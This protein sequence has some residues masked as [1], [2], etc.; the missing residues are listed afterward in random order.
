MRKLKIF[1]LSL[2]L[3]TVAAGI[4][5]L[6]W[7]DGRKNAPAIVNDGAVSAPT[8]LRPVSAN[9]NTPI[10]T[11]KQAGEIIERFN[12]R[13]I[14]QDDGQLGVERPAHR[15]RFT[16]AGCEYTPKNAG[17]A[18]ETD[19]WRLN[20]KR[21]HR[22]DRD[23][24]RA[25]ATEAVLPTAQENIVSLDRGD[26]RER[27]VAKDVGVEL[28]FDL[29]RPPEG[30]GDLVV[31]AQVRTALEWQGASPLGL[32]FGREDKT[33]VRCGHTT[34]VD[35]LGRKL[36]VPSKYEAT[37]ETV[38]LAVSGDWLNHA[39]YPVTID[40][41]IGAPFQITPDSD[42]STGGPPLGIGAIDVAVDTA[43]GRVLVV[44]NETTPGRQ[45]KGALLDD[46][47]S[48]IDMGVPIS[49]SHIGGF[50]N[51][52]AA[53]GNT[54]MFLVVWEDYRDPTA[55][56]YGRRIDI[57]SGTI[58]VLEPSDVKISASAKPQTAPEAA[59][60]TNGVD[61]YWALVW[62]EEHFSP[63]EKIV[64]TALLDGAE[65]IFDTLS[66]AQGPIQISG[67]PMSAGDSYSSPAVA[68]DATGEMWF[69]AFKFTSVTSYTLY[70]KTFDFILD[71]PHSQGTLVGAGTTGKITV[72]Y[73]SDEG[74]PVVGLGLDTS[75]NLYEIFLNGFKDQWEFSTPKSVSLGGNTLANPCLSFNGNFF[76]L[77]FQNNTTNEVF[78]STF[79]FTE[80][81]LN[82]PSAPTLITSSTM[83]ESKPRVV[84]KG[85]ALDDWHIVW[86]GNDGTSFHAM[87]RTLDS[88]E[89][90][91]TERNVS[92]QMPHSHHPAVAFGGGC[93]LVAWNQNGGG[94]QALRVN[95]SGTILDASPLMLGPGG[96][97]PHAS[98]NGTNFVVVWNFYDMG[99]DQIKLAG[100]N[101][102]NGN[103]IE[104]GGKNVIS[105]SSYARLSGLVSDGAGKTLILYDL[106]NMGNQF[107]V[108]GALVDGTTNAVIGSPFVVAGGPDNQDTG[109]AAF[110][111][112]QNLF[113]IAYN[114]DSGTD[115]DV[116]FRRLKSD[117]TFL[118][119]TAQ[120][121]ALGANDDWLT[122]V[123][124]DGVNFT[125]FTADQSGVN[126]TI[127][128]RRFDPAGNAL[129]PAGVAMLTIPKPEYRPTLTF[130]GSVYVLAWEDEIV[131]GIKAARIFPDGTLLDVDNNGNPTP[132]TLASAGGEHP[133]LATGSTALMGAFIDETVPPAE[134]FGVSI[135]KTVLPTAALSV[136][137]NPTTVGTA[138]AF[139]GSA[140]SANAGE[141]T[142]YAF[143]FDDGSP[144]QK[145]TSATASYAY[146]AAGKY[147]ARLTVRN[148]DKGMSH[149]V[150][151]VNI[152]AV[153]D[154]PVIMDSTL[155]AAVLGVPYAH[156]L[157]VVGGVAPYNITVASGALPAGLGI[158]QAFRRIAG[159]TA[160]A[161]GTYSFALKVTDANGKSSTTQTLSI[162]VLTDL[163]NLDPTNPNTGLLLEKARI[164]QRSTSA[165]VLSRKTGRSVP[166]NAVLPETG[167]D[168]IDLRGQLTAAGL[169]FNYAD[170]KDVPVQI[171][172]G[173]LTMVLPLD[174]FAGFRTN[175][176]G[177]DLWVR[178]AVSPQTGKFRLLVRNAAL[179]AYCNN[180]E[181]VDTT[182]RLV[183]VGVSLTTVLG[184]SNGAVAAL[185]EA[186]AVSNQT[187][188]DF[189][190]NNDDLPSG[191]FVLSKFQA[192]EKDGTHAVKIDGRF[193]VGKPLQPLSSGTVKFSI[194]HRVFN[195]PTSAFDVQVDKGIL[196]LKSGAAEGLRRMEFSMQA[197]RFI[198]ETTA[199]KA[200]SDA[201]GN[202]AEA[203]IAAGTISGMYTANQTYNGKPVLAYVLY[204]DLEMPLSDN[205]TL[206]ARVPVRISRK[207]AG[208]LKWGF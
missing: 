199:M 21:I 200:H 14:E 147:K 42:D 115:V 72:D 174:E 194:G 74:S 104:P 98:F 38:L 192:L 37:T 66:V 46:D 63:S 149:A 181:V 137:P 202:D 135:S 152:F 190:F 48:V 2:V 75:I 7:K 129:E 15:L 131:G 154:T 189:R 92:L 95:E 140:S 112:N 62:E 106:Y 120:S 139:D 101:P 159:S 183:P 113:F 13:V 144:V 96:Y 49:E 3:L 146:T 207:S 99:G 5:V 186:K 78:Y 31:E 130:D 197:Q 44:Y 56:I 22:G 73:D 41:I 151:E 102:A 82:D 133:A 89:I 55:Q 187:T 145:G 23:L 26:I 124:F 201:A 107:D 33:I 178:F 122:D 128:A 150:V 54:G 80:G 61:Y 64:K 185:F 177:T 111:A 180:F 28:C 132:F 100:V 168:S 206:K 138:I 179:G 160:A 11:K 79:G 110:A 204:F 27:W 6:R 196:K 34:V 169:S 184:V 71:E 36:S 77:T 175:S 182:R 118:D 163:A 125:V 12:N 166:R 103:I 205:T 155:P 30:F 173:G 153:T 18:V 170:Y 156:D 85:V 191:A 116:Y 193:N 121:V 88:D 158:D 35:A 52:R 117:G 119:A 123:G 164:V 10:M 39:T 57:S 4:S 1:H 25:K 32:N 16:S 59:Y 53:S 68:F 65:K 24:W 97:I 17:E 67:T 157:S 134:V 141:I 58:Q 8:Q 176:S 69:V 127:R 84:S 50:G 47:G 208:D 136:S 45:V 148:T 19:A 105:P 94:I 9:E 143:D 167:E 91:G 171:V 126:I 40:P 93:Y 70:A 165:K 108:Y 142:S 203:D 198:L 83:T 87:T 51:P 114:D 195:I 60:G 29:P 188:Y 43:S 20:V 172:V 161:G 86:L 81:S 109:R 162:A 76:A 90:L